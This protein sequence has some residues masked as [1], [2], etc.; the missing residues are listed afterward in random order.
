MNTDTSADPHKLRMEMKRGSRTRTGS[1]NIAAAYGR[2]SY[3]LWAACATDAR[4]EAYFDI[5]ISAI[6]AQ[7]WR[8]VNIGDLIDIDR[9]FLMREEDCI[10]CRY[11]LLGFGTETRRKT[12]VSL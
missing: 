3:R 7:S 5:S 11:C 6:Y 10:V 9:F 2:L 1:A 12:S 4:A 8:F